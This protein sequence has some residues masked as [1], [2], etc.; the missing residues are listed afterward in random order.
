[1][2]LFFNSTIFLFLLCLSQVGI[3]EEYIKNYSVSTKGIKIGEVVWQLNKDE[4]K[5]KVKISLKSKGLLSSVYKFNGEYLSFGKIKNSLFIPEHYSHKWVT[6]NK[7]K[8]MI[9]QFSQNK[10]DSTTQRPPE[11][12]P[13]RVNLFNLENYSD[14]LTSFISIFYNRD[15]SNTVDGRRIYKMVAKQSLEKPK[16][17]T[18]TITNYKNIYADHKRND[19][20]KIIFS[21][22]DGL[23]L[24]DWIL[25][26]FKGSVFKVYEN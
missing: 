9:I 14:P 12:E 4:N 17:I 21:K 18:I 3:S 1:M 7:V 13:P 23:V 22:Q 5:Y 26:Y 20:E 11:Q 8:D 16:T 19:L 10:I 25:I 15:S 6:K 24:P 2:K